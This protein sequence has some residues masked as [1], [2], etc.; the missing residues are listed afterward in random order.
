VSQDVVLRILALALLAWFIYARFAGKIGGAKAR[1]LVKDGAL[2]LDVRSGAEFGAG[3]L[4]GAKNIPVTDVGA[5]I[6]E[7]PADRS[8]PIVVYCA[9]G[10]RSSMAKRKLKSAGFTQV[11]DVGTMGRYE[12]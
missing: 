6:A 1:E 9:S 2:L 12:G 3:H 11:F 10:M 8:R 4:D 7:L 5:R